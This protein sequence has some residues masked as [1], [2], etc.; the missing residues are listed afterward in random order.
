MLPFSQ[1]E[2]FLCANLSEVNGE[3]MEVRDTG[4]VAAVLRE[5][6][7]P[8]AKLV[9]CRQPKQ[10]HLGRRALLESIQ[11]IPKGQ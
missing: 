11:N 2:L 4:N 9:Q 6:F 10:V 7:D 1:E 3:L 8:L 5:V